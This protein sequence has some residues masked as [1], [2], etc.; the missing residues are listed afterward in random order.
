MERNNS[1]D[2]ARGIAALMVAIAHCETH[3]GG[4]SVWSM[5]V[6]DLFG[7]PKG[8]VAARLWYL[9][10]QADAAV[11]LFFALSG[12]VLSRALESRKASPL[13]EFVPY[14]VR[15]AFRLFPV[16]IAAAF[17]L[18]AVMPLSW[19]TFIGHALLFD[20]S[21]NGPIW[22]LQVELIGCMFVFLLWAVGSR[23][24]ALATVVGG[25]VLAHYYVS[26]QTAYLPIFALGYL[27]PAVPARVWQSR[28]VLAVC[29]TLLWTTDFVLGRTGLAPRIVEALAAF[30]IVGCLT[31]QRVG[32]LLSAPVQFLGR[33]S[34]PFYLCGITSLIVATPFVDARVAGM[35][36]VVQATAMAAFSV[37][38][39]IG[40]AWV[41]HRMAEVPGIRAGNAVLKM[42]STNSARPDRP[43]TN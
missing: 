35:P 9:L 6:A 10:F 25:F 3:F 34:Y 19:K 21:V 43:V 12:Y 37:P 39:C 14:V 8:V 32:L 4:V 33:I 20:N 29:L 42:W 40:L 18:A 23:V 30:G 28:T 26:L 17:L 2:G 24:F 36:L 22:S 5:T 7:Q 1:L 41:I 31:G 11:I 15:R 27:I 13:Q 38:V 16:A